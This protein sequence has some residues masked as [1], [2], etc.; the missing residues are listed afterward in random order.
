VA[1][2][3]WSP[4]AIRDLESIGAHIARDSP[5]IAQAFVD[6][7]VRAVARLSDFPMS[8]R[9]VPEFRRADI[10]EVLFGHYRI[11]YLLDEHVATIVTIFHGSRRLDSA[12][13]PPGM[14][15]P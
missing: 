6:R 4:Q 9:M 14:A 8:G 5:A 3:A 7:I 11:V 15:N 10:R 12:H 13:L 1:R 2:V